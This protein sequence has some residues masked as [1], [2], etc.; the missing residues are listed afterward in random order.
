MVS[1]VFMSLID[2][3]KGHLNVAREVL[4]EYGLEARIELVA[5]AKDKEKKGDKIYRPGRKNPVNLAFHSPVLF[6]L[7]RIRDEA[8][9]FGIRKNNTGE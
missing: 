5:I 6:F 7:M 1:V 8:H 3:G 9:R 4:K 2:G